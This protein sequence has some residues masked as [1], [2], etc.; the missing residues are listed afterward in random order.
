MA[1]IFHFKCTLTHYHT[2]THFH[3][4]KIKSCGKHC[5]E[6]RKCLL[7]AIS[8]FFTMFSTLDG[9]YFSYQMHFN[10]LPHYDAFSR[11]KYIKLWKTLRIK[12]K[13][14]VTSNFSFF[15]NVFYPRWRLFFILNAL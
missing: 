2:M 6:R 8:P 14:L 12:E 11:T 5:E 7:Q 9:A 10:P 13:L 15:H 4:L 3:A 1:L